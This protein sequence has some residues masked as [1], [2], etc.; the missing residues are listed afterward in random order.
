MREGKG[1]G[2]RVGPVNLVPVRLSGRNGGGV[3]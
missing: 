1:S 2:W 3:G